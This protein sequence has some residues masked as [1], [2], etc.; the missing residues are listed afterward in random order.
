MLFRFSIFFNSS[1]IFEIIFFDIE[2]VLEENEMEVDLVLHGT[3]LNILFLDKWKN[4]VIRSP[5][6][7]AAILAKHF[8]I[9]LL[10]FNL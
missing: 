4:I 5:I 6:K 3:F 10:R 7:L 2:L 9:F 8:E 1:G